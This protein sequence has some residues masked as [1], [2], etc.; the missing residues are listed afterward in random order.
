MLKAYVTAV[1]NAS[2]GLAI[3]ATAL[4]I[5][6]M[7]V[8]CQMIAM[9]YVLRQPT[10][11]QTDFVVFSATAA[12]FLGAPYVLLR[13]GHVGVDV[14]EM[15]V[16]DRTRAVLRVVA[17]LLGLLFCVIMLI[18]TWIQFHDAWAGNWK[19]SSVWAPPLWVPLSALPVSFAMLCLQYVAQLLT[20]LTA[21]RAPLTAG[22]DGG[23][24]NSAVNPHSREITP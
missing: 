7:L 21:L 13:G 10:I 23:D 2:R 4:V 9:R 11:W 24:R 20:L 6:S 18:A 8:I 16:G 15:I 14:V 22:Q 17:S 12:M 19:H 3:V 5:T 1:G